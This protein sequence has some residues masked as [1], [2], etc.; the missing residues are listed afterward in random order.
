MEIV[1]KTM[2]LNN[3][4][5]SSRETLDRLD[6]LKDEEIDYSDIPELDEGFWARVQVITSRTKQNVSLRIPEEV[7]AFFK[8]KNPK[9][10]TTRMAAVLNS[11]VRA[12]QPK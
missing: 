8:N 10:Y 4:P 3:P 11:Y 5:K 12:Q 7:V 1:R 6:V 2:D 9:G